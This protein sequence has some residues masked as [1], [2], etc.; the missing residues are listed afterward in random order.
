MT[1]TI[2]APV[3]ETHASEERDARPALVGLGLATPPIRWEQERIAA[4][5]EGLWGLRGA[6][7]D[8][9]R[10]IVAGSG[11]ESRSACAEVAESLGLSTAERMKLYA[12]H[13]PG[14]AHEACRRA[15]LD[16]GVASGRVTDL[17]VVSC[18]GFAAPGVDAALVHSLGLR[19]GVRRTV[20][21][22]MGC[23]GAITGLRAGA[24]A[25]AMTPGSA[26]L[27]VCVELCS[28]H[29][30]R[31]PDPQ[32]LVASALF[33]DGAAAAVVTSEPAARAGVSAGMGSRI[34]L[35]RSLLM[36]EGAGWMTWTIT[37][38]GFAMTLSRDVPRAIEREAPAFFRGVEVDA[39]ASMQT[40]VVHPGGPGVLR[41]VGRGLG[42]DERAL[43]ASRRTLAAHGNMSSGTVLFAL[44]EAAREGAGGPAALAA[45]GPGLSIEALTLGA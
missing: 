8:R 39:G 7:L 32:N 35:G 3:I 42:L 2:D 41:A 6:A 36:G 16:A 43:A 21:G 45:F 10:R 34:G 20:I 19:M 31:D 12:L 28:L 29:L 26:A 37:D 30:R 24:G 15:L 18:T 27:V 1:R 14:L 13:A 11:V 17:I 22:F 40:L 33:A 44:A 4:E 38:E 9:W 5:L 25:C 23:F